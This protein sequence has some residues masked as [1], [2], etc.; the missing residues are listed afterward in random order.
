MEG[1]SFRPGSTYR[2]AQEGEELGTEGF[3]E[4][5]PIIGNNILLFSLNHLESIY[6]K[7]SNCD[8]SLLALSIPWLNTSPPNSKIFS[9]DLIGS[10]DRVP[11]ELRS[12]S[13]E[14]FKCDNFVFGNV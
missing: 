13:N 4:N 9:L 12:E 1:T 6:P 3:S 7:V 5:D 14:T 10:T 11:G 8:N 2:R